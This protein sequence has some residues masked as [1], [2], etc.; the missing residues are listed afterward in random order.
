VVHSAFAA[1]TGVVS[2]A[3]VS[4]HVATT[5]IELPLECAPLAKALTSC[6]FRTAAFRVRWYC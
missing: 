3:L 1:N 2:Q 4:N 6:P 5:F